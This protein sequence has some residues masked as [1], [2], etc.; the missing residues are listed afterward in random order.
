MLQHFAAMV[1]ANQKNED[2]SEDKYSN[3]G[4]TDDKRIG[5]IAFFCGF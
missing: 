5:Y 4:N 3:T 1:V 2:D